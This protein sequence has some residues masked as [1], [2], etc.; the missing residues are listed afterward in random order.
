MGG[1]DCSKRL[2]PKIYDAMAEVI[3]SSQPYSTCLNPLPGLP[4]NG[5]AG[6]PAGAR[7]I[8]THLSEARG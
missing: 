3:R 5:L 2:I 7:R 4:V 1:P 8:F 6:W